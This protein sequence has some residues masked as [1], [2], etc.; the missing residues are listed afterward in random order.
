MLEEKSASLAQRHLNIAMTEFLNSLTQQQRLYQSLILGVTESLA[1][2][3]SFTIE[4]MKFA[5]NFASRE[6]NFALRSCK[7]NL[8]KF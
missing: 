7:M 5:L 2:R 4:T 8:P 6:V 1:T 3:C